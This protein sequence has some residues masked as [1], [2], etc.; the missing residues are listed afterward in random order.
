LARLQSLSLKVCEDINREHIHH[1]LLFTTVNH[2]RP[3]VFNTANIKLVIFPGIRS[4]EFSE[5]PNI[6]LVT[7]PG[8]TRPEHQ[9]KNSLFGIK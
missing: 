9:C 6:K 1:E 8:V 7:F 5:L 3:R 2:V 4:L